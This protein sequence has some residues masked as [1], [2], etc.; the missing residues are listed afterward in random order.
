VRIFIAEDDPVSRLILVTIL[1]KAG[2]DAVAVE[3]GGRALSAL[4][5]PDA[6]RLAILDVMMPVMDGVEVC[7]RLRALPG[8]ERL[9]LIMLTTSNRPENVA[10]GL[11]AGAD[12]YVGK[13]FVKRDLLARVRVGERMIELR[14]ALEKKGIELENARAHIRTLQEGAAHLQALTSH[15]LFT[16]LEAAPET[17]AAGAEKP[18]A[19]KA[20]GDEKP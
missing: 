18:M 13:P 4:S 6:P 11:A 20:G 3:D 9:Y 8:G 10:V 17:F 1:N 7:R 15:P 2:H 5:L 16:G 19:E 14:E 12:D